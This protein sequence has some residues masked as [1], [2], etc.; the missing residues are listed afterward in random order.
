MV[1]GDEYIHRLKHLIAS[2]PNILPTSSTVAEEL[3]SIKK[4]LLSGLDK[5][6]TEQV[7]DLVKR[8]VMVELLLEANT[9]ESA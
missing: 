2:S 4:S 6:A 3:S 5:L 9:D 7:P 1:V 8:S